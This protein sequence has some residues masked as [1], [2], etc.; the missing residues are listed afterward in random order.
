[1]TLPRRLRRRNR[2]DR[3]RPRVGL[4]GLLGS[5]NL[6]NDGSLDVVVH[7]LGT[8]HPEAT[9]SFFCAGPEYVRARYRAEA[10]DLQWY[11]AHA[12]RSGSALAVVLKGFGK[13]A[14]VV[15]TA[16]WVRRQ[17]VVIVP[18]MGVLEAT[19]PLHPWGF[20]Y[21]LF[22]LCAS[23][24]V[25]RTRVALVDVGA[26]VIHRR[27]TRWL[28]ASA[29]RLAHYRSFRDQLSREAMRHNGVDTRG[30][31]VYPDL[32]FGLPTPSGSGDG[33]T[34]GLGVMAYHGG[35]DDRS[36]AAEI[37]AGYLDTLVCFAQGLIDEGWRLRLFTGDHVDEAV[38][39]EIRS[40][41]LADRP[42][43][44][45][46]R[47]AADPPRS[48][49]ELMQEMA[50]VDVVVATRYHNVLCALKL[51][52]PTVSLGYA[53]KNDVL[54]AE[55]GLGEF[56]Q[57]ARSLDLDLLLDQFRTVVSRRAELH[58]V[59]ASRNLANSAR[60]EA[61]FTALTAALFPKSLTARG[62]TAEGPGHRPGYA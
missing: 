18:G 28:F 6:G 55:M 29:A 42:D 45:A 62:S 12:D 30:D 5:G 51:A 54:M 59:L 52:K 13:L 14:D 2:A 39:H 27:A 61:Q 25:F 11:S 57:N 8:E 56:C 20:P 32:V 53:A 7:Y 46:S 35:N 24:R 9:L 49:D 33:H 60:L 58:T 38:A 16:A 47:I 41:V 31:Q 50:L 1:V 36:S 22:L 17:D 15:R 37:H 48:L 4:F 40:R 44:P 43:V 19:L 10:I 21:A 23:G 26:N 34:V 3:R